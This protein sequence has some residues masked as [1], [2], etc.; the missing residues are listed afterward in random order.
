VIVH[1]N[2]KYEDGSGTVT[3]SVTL[4]RTDESERQLLI[5]AI[6]ALKLY[7]NTEPNNMY[8]DWVK[9]ITIT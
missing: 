5:D 7:T 9:E 6:D 3:V 8:R 1:Q 4:S 2:K